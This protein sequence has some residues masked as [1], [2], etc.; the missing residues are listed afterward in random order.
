MP[1]RFFVSAQAKGKAVVIMGVLGLLAPRMTRAW[2]ESA[3]RL[4]VN[5]AV[6]TLPYEIRP[7]FENNRKFLMDHVDDPLGLIDE[8]PWERNNH[9]IELDK[10]GKFPFTTLP[11]SYKAA[12]EKYSKSKI[13]ATGLLPWQIGVDSQKL[14]EGR[15][16]AR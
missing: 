5:H 2:G 1:R 7:F 16:T 8:H 6:D 15:R 13:Q 3:Q 12:I 9:F 10:Y 4:V 11:R 14:T